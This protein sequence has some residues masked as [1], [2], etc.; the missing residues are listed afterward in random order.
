M[1]EKKEVTVMEFA[2]RIYHEV[3]KLQGLNEKQTTILEAL[4]KGVTPEF[5]NDMLSKLPTVEYFDSARRIAK[6][7]FKMEK[8][9]KLFACVFTFNPK[10]IIIYVAILEWYSKEYDKDVIKLEDLVNIF[11]TGLYLEEQLDK[12]W[13][14]SKF[15]TSKS[16]FQGTRDT[17]PNWK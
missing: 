10:H 7:E 6:T 14:D 1:D 12:I 8:G 15:G 16:I 17:K 11:D 4:V 13:E 5:L 9:A 2:E 3:P